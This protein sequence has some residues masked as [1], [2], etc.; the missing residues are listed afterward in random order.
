MMEFGGVCLLKHLCPVSYLL[1]YFF[2]THFYF[3]SA[4]V[5]SNQYSLQFRL[6]ERR[7]QE[8][9]KANTVIRSI[10]SH[11]ALEFLLAMKSDQGTS[12]TT[13]GT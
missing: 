10:H 1:S 12:N 11:Q 13:L 7:I 8:K 4:W 5:R 2:P 6:P 3:F 9:Q